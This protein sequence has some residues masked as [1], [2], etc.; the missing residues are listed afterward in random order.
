MAAI[1]PYGQLAVEAESDPGTEA[2]E[3][4]VKPEAMS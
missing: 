1:D 4:V 2:G 3:V